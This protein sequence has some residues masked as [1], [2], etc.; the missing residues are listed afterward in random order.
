LRNER[1]G[2]PE[3]RASEQRLKS[4]A[5]NVR[6]VGHFRLTPPFAILACF[7][8]A[9]ELTWGCDNSN[10][11]HVE[12][13]A[14]QWRA[15]AAQALLVFLKW[16]TP[17]KSIRNLEEPKVVPKVGSP[18]EAFTSPMRSPDLRP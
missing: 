6:A 10:A 9:P 13:G 2:L 11:D 14:L 15:A 1:E 7:R 12:V 4:A 16:A 18:D 17:G 8:F 3:K 5:A